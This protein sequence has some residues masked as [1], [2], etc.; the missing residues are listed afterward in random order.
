MNSEIYLDPKFL[1]LGSNI[2]HSKMRHHG[3]GGMEF[4]KI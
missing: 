1:R 2:C 3:Y 4:T